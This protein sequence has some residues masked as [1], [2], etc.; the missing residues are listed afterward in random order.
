M[1]ES[2]VYVM[3]DAAGFVKVG[4]SR[5]LDQRVKA[6]SADRGSSVELIW[7]T[8]KRENAVDVEFTTH[9]SL[10]PM[11]SEREW[12]AI[13]ADRAVAAVIDAIAA[14]DSGDLSGR[15]RLPSVY[16]RISPAKGGPTGVRFEADEL[17]ALARAAAEDER[18]PSALLRKIAAEWLRK[19]GWLTPAKPGRKQGG[20]E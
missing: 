1:S 4:V 12:F 3:R 8:T 11:R 7:A 16:K 18:P 6:V 17:D 10:L 14:V 15:K 13:D 20:V 9:T 19:H 5:S 2:H